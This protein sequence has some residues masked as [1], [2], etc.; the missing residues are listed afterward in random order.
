MN[1]ARTSSID[2]QG[3]GLGLKSNEGD[4]QDYR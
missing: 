4:D 2:V 1:G 3:L